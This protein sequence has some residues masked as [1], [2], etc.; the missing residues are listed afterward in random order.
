MRRGVGEVPPATGVADGHQT[1]RAAGLLGDHVLHGGDELAAVGENGFSDTVISHQVRKVE[2]L[3]ER[4]QA[5]RATRG[6]DYNVDR[7]VSDALETFGAVGT[8]LRTDE[9]LNGNG[10]V[11]CAFDIVL[12]DDQTVIILV[13]L[14]RIRGR[15]NCVVRRIGGERGSRHHR[16][17]DHC[18]KQPFEHFFLP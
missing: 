14:I 10:A 16:R 3:H 8:Q 18:G 2:N 1:D 9:Q 6:L 12:E 17:D 7:A 5:G 15:A 11:G 13:I 4:K